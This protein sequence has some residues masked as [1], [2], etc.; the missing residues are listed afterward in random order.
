[1]PF[2]PV[3]GTEIYYE[4]HGDGPALVFAHGAGGNHLSWWHQV[5][6]F[7][8]HF[9]CITFDHRGFGFSRDQADSPGPKAFGDD[10]RG[11]LDH[12]G[13]ERANLVSQSMGGWTITA[14]AV[15]HPERVRTLALCDTMGGVDDPQIIEEMGR[16]GAPRGGLADVL[17]RV[18]APDFPK[19]EP[20][21]TFLYR[22][23][24]ALNINTPPNLV[25]EMMK[26]RHDM[27]PIIKNK[28]PA[29]VLVGDQDE[30]TTPRLMELISRRIPHSRFVKI[31]G[32]GHSAYFERPEVFN[33]VLL[34]FLHD[35]G[36]DRA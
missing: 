7:A 22:E 32:S 21:K 16:H 2:A 3:N 35:S 28:I 29:L 17:T 31:E 25:P 30:L 20:L 13:I 23:I 27:T 1:M 12:L 10:L 6:I 8:P 4:S 11:L 9:R 36:G 15:A 18:Y 14:F 26:L 5:P 33:R 24:S 19:R 34:E